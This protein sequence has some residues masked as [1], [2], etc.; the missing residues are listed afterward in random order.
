MAKRR[1]DPVA[2]RRRIY[3]L[4][5][6]ALAENLS[7]EELLE[8]YGVMDNDPSDGLFEEIGDEVR[9]REPEAFE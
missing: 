6:A 3:G 1:K 7:P 4:A 5:A 8:L 2:A 9:R